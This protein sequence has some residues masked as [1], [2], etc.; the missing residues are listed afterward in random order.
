VVLDGFDVM[1]TNGP[2]GGSISDLVKKN[3]VI[4]STDQVAADSYGLSLLGM[5][6]EDLPYI[7]MAEKAGVGTADYKLL[8]PLFDSEV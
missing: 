3:T 5:N 6:R 4:V 2:T 7:G 1:M 8:K